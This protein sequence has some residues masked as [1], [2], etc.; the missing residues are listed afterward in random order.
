[1]GGLTQENAVSLLHPFDQE[2]VMH[3]RNTLRVTRSA[4]LQQLEGT[5]GNNNTYLGKRN[6]D[7]EFSDLRP[8]RV[9]FVE[10]SAMDTSDKDQPGLIEVEKWFTTLV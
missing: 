5:T 8:M 4:A 6:K 3:F 1:L 2:I 9:Q 10:C 7:F